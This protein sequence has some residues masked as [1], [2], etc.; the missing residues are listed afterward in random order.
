[1]DEKNL[2]ALEHDYQSLQD[3]VRE[4]GF[5]APGSVIERY[6]VCAAPT[7]R[8]HADPPAPHGPYFQYTRKLA[9]KT[10][11]RRLNG[12]QAE[13]YREWITNRRRL[14]ELL[15]QMDQIS[16]RAADLMLARTVR[17]PR[18]SRSEP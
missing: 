11:T 1:M 18:P 12:E 3:Q 10:L 17:D 9:G 14:D 15:G 16:R 4:L 13:R 2:A 8:C 5:V 6:T 7:C